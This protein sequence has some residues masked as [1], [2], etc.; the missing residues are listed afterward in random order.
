MIRC[1]VYMFLSYFV[2]VVSASVYWVACLLEVK[3]V[4][5]TLT[6]HTNIAKYCAYVC[7]CLCVC[8]FYLLDKWAIRGGHYISVADKAAASKSVT[9]KRDNDPQRVCTVVQIC[10]L[11][12]V[13]FYTH[14][15]TFPYMST[16]LHAMA[17]V[18]I[19][20]E[21]KNGTIEWGRVWLWS[22]TKIVRSCKHTI[23]DNISFKWKFGRKTCQCLTN[24][25]KIQST[26]TMKILIQK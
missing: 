6:Q 10:V 13:R 17:M 8:L 18:E 21:T 20:S 7:F 3:A 4:S 26:V 15:H 24:I 14:L 12:S 22:T 2:S 19:Q 16:Y 1:L 9:V 5:R 23:L 11:I 25:N